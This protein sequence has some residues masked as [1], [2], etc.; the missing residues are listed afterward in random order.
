MTTHR[1][2]MSECNTSFGM[3]V[4]I[5]R[6]LLVSSVGR[7]EKTVEAHK[8]AVLGALWSHDGTAL[9]TSIYTHSPLH[10]HTQYPCVLYLYIAVHHLHTH[11]QYPYKCLCAVCTV[12]EHHRWRR[13]SGKS[14]VAI[15]HAENQPGTIRYSPFPIPYITTFTM[16]ISTTFQRPQSIPPRGRRNRTR[17]STPVG[18]HW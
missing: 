8:G 3:F 6:F 13:W 10:T 14:V 2:Y 1:L 12:A 9:I 11:T 18:G 7:V 4:Y 17:S 15:R 5:G 16:Y